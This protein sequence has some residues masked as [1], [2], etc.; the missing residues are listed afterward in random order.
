MSVHS[1]LA[2]LSAIPA[3]LL[4]HAVAQLSAVDSY[5]LTS[6]RFWSL[7]GAVVGLVGA[8]LGGVALARPSGRLGT[9][10]K[11][12]G[13]IVALGAGVVSAVAG[14]GVVAAAE[15][16]PGTGYGIVGGYLAIAVGLI[17][18]ALGSLALARA[19]RTA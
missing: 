1:A 14:G 3:D 19:R 13:A 6:G 5:T 9:G 8:V 10:T 11:P 2:T 7:V 15:G 17:A 18:V 12:R 16:G 4:A